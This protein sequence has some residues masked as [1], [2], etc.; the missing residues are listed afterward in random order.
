MSHISSTN[1]SAKGAA[2]PAKSDTNA[3]R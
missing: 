1:H 3:H 2:T